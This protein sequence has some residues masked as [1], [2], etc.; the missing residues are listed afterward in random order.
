MQWQFVHIISISVLQWRLSCFHIP[1]VGLSLSSLAPRSFSSPSSIYLYIP[2]SS[3]PTPWMGA[4]FFIFR[5]IRP[6][7]KRSRKGKFSMT[8]HSLS[9]MW[10]LPLWLQYFHM[11]EGP[12]IWYQKHDEGRKGRDDFF[13]KRSISAI[14]HL[15]AGWNHDDDYLTSHWKRSVWRISASIPPPR[16]TSSSGRR[17][18]LPLGAG[19][20]GENKVDFKTHDKRQMDI[21]S[22]NRS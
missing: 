17:R 8:P 19:A 16:W 2:D 22:N 10:H 11:K 20:R 3:F 1:I 6:W 12:S 18:L 13:F 5:S 21:I 9:W 7:R 15:L 4:H 14:E